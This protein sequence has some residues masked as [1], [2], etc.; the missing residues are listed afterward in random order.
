MQKSMKGLRIKNGTIYC[1][2]CGN[3]LTPVHK[4]TQITGA[5]AVYCDGEKIY[6]C[7]IDKCNY[8]K[9]LL[10]FVYYNKR[11]GK[12]TIYNIKNPKELILR[13][14][15]SR[16]MVVTAYFMTALLFGILFLEKYLNK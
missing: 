14:I 4:E 8:Y 1:N 2:E 16:C 13:I 7:T 15:F 5:K 10:N 6:Y 11:N 3:A 9:M 12:V